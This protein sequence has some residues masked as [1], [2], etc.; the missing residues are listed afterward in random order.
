MLRL[1]VLQ[2]VQALLV[3][4]TCTGVWINLKWNHPEKFKQLFTIKNDK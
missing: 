4:G 1:I 2:G 3:G